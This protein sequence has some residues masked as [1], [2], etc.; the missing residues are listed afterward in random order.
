MALTTP[1]AVTPGQT[2]TLLAAD[3]ITPTGSPLTIGGTLKI[4]VRDAGLF[5]DATNHSAQRATVEI[6][7]TLT[8]STP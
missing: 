5:S 2:I 3:I 4:I 6:V 7:T 1:Q 8:A